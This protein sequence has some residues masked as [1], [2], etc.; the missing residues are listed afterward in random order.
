ML[1]HCQTYLT[2][3]E[4]Q[5]VTSWLHQPHIQVECVL[6]S[7]FVDKFVSPKFCTAILFLIGSIQFNVHEQYAPGHG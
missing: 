1:Q 3:N 5:V 6:S 2:Q 7:E 4:T